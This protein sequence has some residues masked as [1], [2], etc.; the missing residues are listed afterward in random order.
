MMTMRMIT[1][2]KPYISQK[3]LLSNIYTNLS[4]ATHC[5]WSIWLIP[6]KFKPIANS[7]FR[8][9]NIFRFHYKTSQ[10]MLF[11]ETMLSVDLSGGGGNQYSGGKIERF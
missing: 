5:R 10:L 9:Q 4:D 7:S 8:T 1:L 3:V 2:S 6:L 11:V